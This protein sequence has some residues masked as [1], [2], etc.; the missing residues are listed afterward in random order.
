MS[1]VSPHQD[2]Q[3]PRSF[4]LQH[5]LLATEAALAVERNRLAA[6]ADEALREHAACQAETVRAARA[7]RGGLGQHLLAAGVAHRF[8]R[9][10]MGQTS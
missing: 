9:L 3:Q 7:G 1:D 10:A 4:D 8:H 5:E 2:D 6:L